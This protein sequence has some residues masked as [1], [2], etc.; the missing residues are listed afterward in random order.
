MSPQCWFSLLLVFSNVLMDCT[1]LAVQHHSIDNLERDSDGSYRPRDSDHYGD[2]GH[3]ADF[4]HEAILGSVREAEEFD[5]LSPDEAKS[6]L[7]DML[8]KMDSNSDKHIDR[9]ELKKW[10]LGSFQTL[11]KE[12]AAERL[13]EADTNRDGIVSW[14]E[15][16]QDTFGA[17]TEEEIAGDEQGD[18]GML[19][20]EEKAMWAA[21]DANGD[22]DLNAEEFEVFTNPEEH[23][24]MHPYLVNQT[25]REKDSN[26]DGKID[27]Q[28]FV[29]DRVMHMCLVNQT[30]REKDSN[31][32]GKVD[33]QE[34]VGDRG[35]TTSSSFI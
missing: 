5:R 28:E 8:P 30:L 3:N 26:K 34:F 21:A 13:Q 2:S 20:A 32:D 24:V 12:E 10:I 11:S 25:L 15:Y 27:F 22:G 16:L 31:K 17:D 33:F 35:E 7:A 1:S 29:G 14:S 19:V 18:S 6:R 4:D 9:A 23:E